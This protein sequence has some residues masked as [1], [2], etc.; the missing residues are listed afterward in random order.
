MHIRDQSAA[1]HLTLHCFQVR[2]IKTTLNES[3]KLSFI[4]MTLSLAL[5]LKET[6]IY[7]DFFH[8]W[9]EELLFN[10][11]LRQTFIRKIC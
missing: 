11:N 2:D 8:L 7:L 4:K 1:T 6:N 9:D 3:Q 10:L 5:V